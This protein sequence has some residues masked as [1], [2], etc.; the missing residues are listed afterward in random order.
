MYITR[1]RYCW[2]SP[3]GTDTAPQ[4]DWALPGYDFVRAGFQPAVVVAQYGSGAWGATD[5]CAAG[6]CSDKALFSDA[7]WIWSSPLVSTGTPSLFAY[8]RLSLGVSSV[9]VVDPPPPANP[10]T[11]DNDMPC[12]GSSSA[13]CAELGWAVRAGTGFA[14]VCAASTAVGCVADATFTAAQQT[15]EQAGGRLCTAEEML[16]HVTQG[17]GCSFDN[18]RIWTSDRSVADPA[19]KCMFFQ[20]FGCLVALILTFWRYSV[21]ISQ[22]RVNFDKASLIA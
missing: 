11:G 8:C 20:A 4:G 10:S 21:N 3:D 1:S 13:S 18:Q 9:V 15:C 6:Q 17:S 14:S 22:I 2:S 12:R 16:A 5:L 7:S 19:Q